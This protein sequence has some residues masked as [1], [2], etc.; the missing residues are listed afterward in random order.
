[1]SKYEFT[2]KDMMKLRSAYSSGYRTKETKAA[3]AQYVDLRRKNKLEDFKAAQLVEQ[4][5]KA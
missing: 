3:A 5:L 1:M 4:E 2:Y